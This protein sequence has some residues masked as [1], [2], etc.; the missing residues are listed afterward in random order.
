MMGLTDLANNGRIMEQGFMHE[1]HGPDTN[2]EQ[3]RADVGAPPPISTKDATLGL[4]NLARKVPFA[5]A[6][7]RADELKMQVMD[8]DWSLNPSDTEANFWVVVPDKAIYLPYAGLASLW[9]LCRVAFTVMDITSRMNRS[10]E[11]NGAGQVDLGQQ[12]ADYRLDEYIAYARGLV[13]ADEDWPQGLTVPD[14][15]AASKSWEGRLNNMFLGALSWIMLH[16][17]GHA[18]YLHTKYAGAD[19]RVKQEHQADAFATSWILEKAGN[20]INREFRV[21]MIITALAW[22]FLHEQVKKGGTDHPPTILRLREAVAGFDLGERSSAA[23]NGT[24]LLKAIFDPANENMPT[25]MTP[26]E[27]FGWM[28]QRMEEIS[29]R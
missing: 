17:I 10:A 5:I 23:E 28:V 7:E 18:H 26:R 13:A 25:K 2:A 9:C 12:W 27:A 22:V 20:G 4:F 21:L 19:H 24:Y 16:E 1:D 14:A 29:P 8:K 15:A 3:E 11:T 6:P